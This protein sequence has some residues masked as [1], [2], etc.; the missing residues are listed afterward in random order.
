MP[1]PLRIGVLLSLT[2]RFARFGRQGADALEL[3]NRMA[4]GPARLELRDDAG[5]TARVA[6]ALAGLARTCDLLL[7]PYSTVLMREAAGFARETGTLVWNHGGSGDDVQAAAPGAVVSVLTPTSGYADPFVG[8]L[9][10]RLPGT[11]L[12][13]VP[14]RGSFGRQVIAGARASA[15]RRGVPVVGDPAPARPSARAPARAAARTPALFTAGTF[16][17]DVERVSRLPSGPGRPPLVGTVAAGVQ[18]FGRLVPDPQ[19]VLGVAQ[20]VP[21][22]DPGPVEVGPDEREF[23]HRHRAAHGAAPDYPGVQAAATAALAVHCAGLAGST[24]AGTLFRV[25][26]GLRTR[27]LYGDFAIDPVTG[28][29]TGHAMALVRWRDGRMVPV[30]PD[31]E[32]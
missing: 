24:D 15:E 13:L 19:G 12:R 21:G 23:L 1:A 4:G 7:G 25:A 17:E 14:G 2:G 5:D 3:W 22:G 8:H 26:A 20:W 32:D 27:T 28:A 9:A 6:P 18:D 10:E 16:E 29:Q 31:Q 11:G 30:R